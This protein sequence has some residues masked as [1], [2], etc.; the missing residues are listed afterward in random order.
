MGAAG[1]EDGHVGPLWLCFD[2]RLTLRTHGALH[3]FK[4]EFKFK[5]ELKFKF[6]FVRWSGAQLRVGASTCC[7]LSWELVGMRMGTWALYGCA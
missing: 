3:E 1:N 4:F 2:R 5:F 6:E 7:G